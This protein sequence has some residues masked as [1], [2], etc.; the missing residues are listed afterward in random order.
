MMGLRSLNSFADAQQAFED[1]CRDAEEL[2][3]RLKKEL[4]EEEEGFGIGRGFEEVGRFM[5]EAI[6][7]LGLDRS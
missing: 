1:A 5:R 6:S 3:R 7:K 2:D 4:D